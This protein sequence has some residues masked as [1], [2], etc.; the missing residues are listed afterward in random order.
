[1]ERKDNYLIQTEEAKR[2]FLRYDQQKLIEKL[3]L[4]HDGEYLYA[5]MLARLYRIHRTMACL[6]RQENGCWVDANSFEEVLTFLDLLCD[7]REDRYLSLRWKNLQDFGLMF[8]RN[9]LENQR[10]PY[11]ERFGA[12]P[13]G[14]RRACVALGGQPLPQGDVSYAIELFDGLPIAVQL[15]LGDEEFP[16]RL[17]FLLDENANMYLRYETMYYAK[18][19]LL[20]RL[21]NI[22]LSIS[23]EI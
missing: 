7:S 5:V 3:K 12:D 11:A 22:F 16:P 18:A 20:K 2:R 1:M 15:W 13:E 6:Q 8:H 10:D 14:F 23:G 4:R 19:L 21:E 9:L 17:R